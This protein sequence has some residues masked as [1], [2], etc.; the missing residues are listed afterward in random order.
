[1]RQLWILQPVSVLA[2]FDRLFRPQRQFF[3]G[4]R[5]MGQSLVAQGILQTSQRDVEKVLPWTFSTMET[6]NGVSRFLHFQ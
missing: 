4:L 2:D 5:I 6:E 3:Y 1:M